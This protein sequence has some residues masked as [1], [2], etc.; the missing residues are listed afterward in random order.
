MIFGQGSFINDP[1][2]TPEQVAQKRK[3]ISDIMAGRYGSARTPAEGWAHLATGIMSGIGDIK[4]SKMEQDRREKA[5]QEYDDKITNWNPF[6]GGTI[7]T[8]GPRTH[9][10]DGSFGDTY[11]ARNAAMEATGGP[12]RAAADQ[13][14]GRD[15]ELLARTLMA[16]AGGEGLQGMLAAGSV[17]N[18]RLNAGGYGDSL[19]GVIMKP[20]QFSAWNG[21]TGYAGGEGGL[22]MANMTPSEQ[23][24]QAA[25]AILSGQYQDPTG[26]ATHYYNPAAANPAWG[27]QGGGDWT[28]IGNHVFGS[29]DAGRGTGPGTISTQGGMPSMPAYSGPSVQDLAQ[30]AANP[31][32]TPEQRSV[33][34]AQLQQA[35]QATDPMRQLQWQQAQ[36]DLALGQAQLDQLRN[37]QPGFRQV[38]GADLGLSGPQ[39][40]AM[41][42]VGPD[43]KVSQIG[44]GGTNVSIN[45]GEGERDRYVYGSDAGV[46]AGWRVDRQTGQAS[47]IPGGPAAQEAAQLEE[48]RGMREEQAG[49]SANIVMQDINRA[50]EQSN[51]WG[52]TGFVGGL[53]GG[54]GGTDAHD[55]QNT[56]RTVQANI[57]F[58]R[59]QQMREASPTGGALGAVSERE[60]TE[61]QAVLGSIQQS[62]S[63]EQLQRNLTRLRDV[64]SGILQK[65]SAYP[66]AAEFGFGAPAPQDGELPEAAPNYLTD[67]DKEL[68]DVMT[69][70]E[71]RAILGSY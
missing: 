43:G 10:A 41:F 32:L 62:Q 38:R 45:T 39:A 6:G 61:L 8:S 24:Y 70:E 23:A 16:E 9:G 59:L 37:P 19:E 64:Y 53:L 49:R 1:N 26:G 67:Q 29:A 50:L 20:G 58:D 5:T 31:W 56:L 68:W 25:D 11:G 7:S 69:P 44:G 47:P 13:L 55:L 52:T 60:L 42:N 15:R 12:T 33:V 54:W 57:G 4:L 46:P 40:D 34:T 3:A 71:R 51:D 36:Q 17:I 28:R 35:Q 22:D 21:V 14:N 27:A 48:Q 63:K 2:A 30:L 66:N 65:A 18:N